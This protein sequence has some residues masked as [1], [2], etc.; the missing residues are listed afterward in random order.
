[1]LIHLKLVVNWKP[2]LRIAFKEAITGETQ[3]V[4]EISD[5][6]FNIRSVF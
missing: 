5:N 2:V 4:V 3:P 1:M 6:N